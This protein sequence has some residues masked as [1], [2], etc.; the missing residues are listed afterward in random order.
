MIDMC[1]Q[2]EDLN[3]KLV[4]ANG[5]ERG[6]AFPTGCS[7]NH[8]AAHYS[9]NPNDKDVTFKYDDVMKVDFGTQIKGRIIDCAW[10]VAP[11]PKFKPLLDTVKEAT[12]TGIRH[13]GIDARL[14]EIGEAIQEVMEAGEIELDGKVHRSEFPKRF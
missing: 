10:T 8:I 6:I 13:A 12:N 2:I 11:N 4:Q 9:P 1:Q 14:N 7:I 3:R 5:L